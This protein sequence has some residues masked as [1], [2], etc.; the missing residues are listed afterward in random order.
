MSKLSRVIQRIF[1][2]TGGS[3]EFGVFG[4]NAAT[5]PGTNTKDLTTIQSLSQYLQGWFSATANASEPPRI[6]DRNSLDLLWSSQLAYLFQNGA[7]EW[8]NDADQRYY[9][10]I[11]FVSYG[12]DL[13]Q[14]ILGDDVTNINV[15]KQPDT[16]TTWW[17]IVYAK[18]T[19][20]VVTTDT[21]INLASYKDDYTVIAD[22]A[23]ASTVSFS[24]VLRSGK[25]LKINNPSSDLLVVNI[26]S[27]SYS[28]YP[29][30]SL[31]FMSDGTTMNIYEQTSPANGRLYFSVDSSIDLSNYFTDLICYT[32]SVVT[33]TI[34]GSLP[35][36]RKLTVIG[37]NTSTAILS[38]N[39]TSYN[40]TSGQ[41]YS[42]LSIG[43]FMRRY[44]DS[45]PVGTIY[46]QVLGG[47]TPADLNFVGT[48][49]NVS[50]SH[51][52]LFFRAE[53]GQAAA[54]GGTQQDAMQ[55]VTAQ[56]L[57]FNASNT[58]GGLSQPAGAF[59]IAQSTGALG[60]G[61]SGG[62]VETKYGQLDF[63]SSLSTF[64]NAAKTNDVET[65][66]SNETIRVWLRSA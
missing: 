63:D 59:T 49:T 43:S 44:S 17:K 6:E 28:V 31:E 52:G 3:G 13:Y 21:P 8:L 35:E 58:G 12:G 15:Q 66:P 2:E 34:T 36:G 39:S 30:N 40:I 5:P 56:V 55:R 51:A 37:T 9:E 53:G 54:Y 24:N 18:D 60:L 20:E 62:A 23:S 10:D 64:P 22:L 33:L 16:E 48:W 32:D 27:V 42:F 57:V 14:A 45:H 1:G 47:L 29:E 65:R 26:N 50:A 46:F 19:L 25:I 7:P 61:G 11:S 4:S 41:E 38:I